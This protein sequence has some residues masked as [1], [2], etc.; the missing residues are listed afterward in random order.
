MDEGGMKVAVEAW[1]RSW[2]W[3]KK[4]GSR[5]PPIGIWARSGGRYVRWRAA[6]IVMVIGNLFH[7]AH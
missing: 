1:R 6:A 3:V 2:Q 7:D 4:L 5:K